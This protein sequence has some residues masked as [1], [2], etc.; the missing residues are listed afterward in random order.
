MVF[1]SVD[2]PRATNRAESQSEGGVEGTHKT[3]QAAVK[4]LRL[5]IFARW[6][7]DVNLDSLLSPW[8]LRHAARRR[9]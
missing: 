2:S 8:V 7:V 1:V 5:D 9:N 4:A 3:L 6:E